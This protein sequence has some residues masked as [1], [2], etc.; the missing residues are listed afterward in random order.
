MESR[1]IV[2]GVILIL[3]GVALFILTWREVRRQNEVAEHADLRESLR[4]PDRRDQRA[5]LPRV[6]LLNGL[7]LVGMG[8]SVL[9]G[10]F[11]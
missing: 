9:F 5:W 8:I 11:L 3:A 1:Q 4:A 6:F 2:V 7:I 10:A